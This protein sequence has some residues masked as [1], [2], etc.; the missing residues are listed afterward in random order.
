MIESIRIR[1]VENGFIVSVTTV[2]EKADGDE[3]WDTE[4]KVFLN[5]KEAVEFLQ[6][7]VSKI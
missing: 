3:D 4:E 7:T 5:K 1:P 2:T 6:E